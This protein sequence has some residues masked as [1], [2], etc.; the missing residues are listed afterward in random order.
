VA[1]DVDR[2]PGAPE[3]ID[4]TIPIRIVTVL[5]SAWLLPGLSPAEAA[6][7]G[8]PA[9]EI[10]AQSWL[11]VAQPPARGF[12]GHVTLVEFWTYGCWNCRNVEPHVKQWYR[13]YAPRGLA[14]VAVHTP[15]LKDEY[16]VD[17]VAAYLEQRGIAYPV[18]IDND[19][20]NWNR[21][22]NRYWPALYLIDKRGVLRHV[23]VGEGGYD[24]TA[25]L[26]EA[27]LAEP[28]AS[29]PARQGP[30]P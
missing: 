19:Y 14:V 15:E 28:V 10:R 16:D 1:R 21:Y 12:A 11:N 7:L 6:S 4:M 27:L 3:F 22:A 9:P 26:I 5:L 2:R 29:T 8:A 30:S 25:R 13:D 18:A 23:H 17:K 24:E 20:S